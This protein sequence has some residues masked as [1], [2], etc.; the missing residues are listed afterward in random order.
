MTIGI[1]A[2][3]PNAGRAILLG[4]RAAERVGTGALGGFVAF[5]GIAG[6]RVLRAETQRGGTRGL[7]GGAGLDALS[8]ELAGVPCAGLIS[9]GPDRP[10]PL[11]Q[12]V[13]ARAGVGLVTG[14][15]LPNAPGA[16]GRAVN[17]RLLDE[18]A[19]GADPAGALLRL[20]DEEP[21]LDA[22][23]IAL[24]VDGRRALG[25]T[26]SVAGRGDV[27]RATSL[28]AVAEPGDAARS[29]ALVLHNSIEPRGSLAAL[30]AEIAAGAMAEAL[31]EAG[32]RPV[33]VRLEAGTPLRRAEDAALWVDARRRVVRIDVTD[34]RLLSGERQLGLG[35]RVPVRAADGSLLGRVAREPLL[36]CREGRVASVDGRGVADVGV[37]PVRSTRPA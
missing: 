31:G 35:Y 27:G 2:F 18:M 10:E 17:E 22:G 6:T 8:A 21:L 14:H 24:A 32:A 5:A 1:A 4:L 9:S 29:V 33:D 15:R 23:L 16:D 20:L 7:F 30:V 12:F 26:A 19:A 34:V 3:G 37:V 25:D 36:V 13:A 11:A 28:A